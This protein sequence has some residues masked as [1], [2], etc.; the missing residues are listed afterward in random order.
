ML[1]RSGQDPGDRRR[2]RL[3]DDVPDLVPG[4]LHGV[5]GDQIVFSMAIFVRE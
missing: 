5:R 2:A 1:W 3:V 4:I